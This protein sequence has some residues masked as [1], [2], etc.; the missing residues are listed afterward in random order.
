MFGLFIAT[1][2]G[3]ERSRVRISLQVAA[4]I[5]DVCAYTFVPLAALLA[6]VMVLSCS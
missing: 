3:V 2:N 1:G 6:G 5:G 4:V